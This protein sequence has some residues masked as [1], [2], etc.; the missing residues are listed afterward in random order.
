MVWSSSFVLPDQTIFSWYF[1]GLSKYCLTVVSLTQPWLPWDIVVE[2][3]VSSLYLSLLPLLGM[4]LDVL[5]WLLTPFL[6][7]LVWLGALP[8]YIFCYFLPP[9]LEP[10]L[11]KKNVFGTTVHSDNNSN[12]KSCQT[13]RIE[14]KSLR[15]FVTNAISMSLLSISEASE[16]ARQRLKAFC[17]PLKELHQRDRGQE[18]KQ[19]I[20]QWIIQGVLS[21]AAEQHEN[22]PTKA[23]DEAILE[24]RMGHGHN[25]WQ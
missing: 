1:T 12:G 25:P 2:G 22:S 21:V 7:G 14:K 9:S 11:E 17:Q 6:G 8:C 5:V 23:G 3:G 20:F 4:Q 19:A 10:I 24:E 13:E 16:T 18:N 15:S